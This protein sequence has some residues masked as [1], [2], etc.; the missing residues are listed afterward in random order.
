MPG[1]PQVSNQLQPQV[2]V[3]LPD[4]LHAVYDIKFTGISTFALRPLNCLKTTPIYTTIGI[5][6]LGLSDE[7]VLIRL[8]QS[9][10]YLHLICFANFGPDGVKGISVS[11][12][13]TTV[14]LQVFNYQLSETDSVVPLLTYLNGLI[15]GA[16]STNNRRGI[17]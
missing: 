13:R 17:A 4:E 5:T 7:K 16:T 15:N 2:R 8:L 6:P 11:R 12:L 3:Y 1:R 14:R 10:Y 9:G